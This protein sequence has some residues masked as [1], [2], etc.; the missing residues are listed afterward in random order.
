MSLPLRLAVSSAALLLVLAPISGAHGGPA[1]QVKGA[2]A[3]TGTAGRRWLNKHHCLRCHSLDGRR[4]VGPTFAGRWGQSVEVLVAGR[5]ETRRFDLA[6]LE[7]SI[8]KPHA[9]LAVGYPA[10]VMPRGRIS[11]DALAQVAAAL[12]AA[13][14]PA[15]APTPGSWWMLILGVVLFAGLHLLLPV[16]PL[17]RGLVGAVGLGPYKGIYSLIALAGMVFTIWGWIRA[18]YHELWAPLTSLRHASHLLMLPAM[19][20]IVCGFSTKS[21]TAADGEKQLDTKNAGVQGVLRITRHPGLWGFLL[22]GLA[23]LLPN[24]DLAGVLF[25]GSFALLSLLG[26]LHI[27]ARRRAAEGERW[28]R[29]ASQTSLFP[30]VAILR[31]KTKL[32]LGEIGL[33]RLIIVLALFALLIFVHPYLFGSPAL[34]VLSR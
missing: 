8:I 17:R 27:D 5:R 24:G 4:L 30:F 28:E 26:M 11:K 16:G 1:P 3:E 29:F 31:G 7:R 13:K 33:P 34:Y 21:P 10:K 12:K 6:Y 20:F 25:F 15:K 14:A 22:W 2:A 9:E 32:A 18:P 19:F 23:H